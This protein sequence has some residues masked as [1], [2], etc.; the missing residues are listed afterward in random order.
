MSTGKYPF[1]NEK[2]IKRLK[3]SILS[4]NPIYPQDINPAIKDMIDNLLCKSADKRRIFVRERLRTHPMFATMDWS[5]LESGKLSPSLHVEPTP[6][7]DDVIPVVAMLKARQPRG[8]PITPEEQ[9]E[10]MDFSGISSRWKDLQPKNLQRTSNTIS[11]S[12]EGALID[13]DLFSSTTSSSSSSFISPIVVICFFSF[14]FIFFCSYIL[15][16]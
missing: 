5:E 1:Y 6:V 2:D 7:Q 11:S 14:L 8:P 10:F 4:D 12:V 3:M 9:R 13:N 15:L 16:Y